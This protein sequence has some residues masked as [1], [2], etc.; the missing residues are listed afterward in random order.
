MTLEIRDKETREMATEIA[1][2][3]GMS[4]EEAVR[5]ALEEK[6]ER[7]RLQGGG[8]RRPQT[9]EEWEEMMER[10]IWSKIPDELLDQPPMTKEEKE[11]L[12][13]Y[14]PEGF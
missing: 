7:M 14:G 8:R 5:Q 4:E 2:H 9:V 6:Q 12:L 1:R 13:G 3:I 10:E 11:E